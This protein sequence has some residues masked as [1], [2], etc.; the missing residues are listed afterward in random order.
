MNL[1]RFYI[2]SAS[3]IIPV[4][5]VFFARRAMASAADMSKRLIDKPLLI[6]IKQLEIKPPFAFLRFPV[7]LFV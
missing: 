7:N 2:L 1:F 5:S 6:A 3:F 4:T